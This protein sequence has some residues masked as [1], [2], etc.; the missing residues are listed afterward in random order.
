MIF[1]SASIYGADVKCEQF[2]TYQD[3]KKYYQAHKHGYQALDRNNNGSPCEHLRKGASKKE[4]ARI[5]IEPSEQPKEFIQFQ[6][7]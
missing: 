3:A 6:I 5:R 2:N 4:R 1:F 7:L